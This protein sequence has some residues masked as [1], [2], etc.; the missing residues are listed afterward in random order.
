MQEA[1]NQKAIQQRMGAEPYMRPTTNTQKYVGAGIEF[2][3]DPLNLVGLP[4]RVGTGALSV[5]RQVAPTAVGGFTAGIASEA[6]GEVGKELGGTT[7]QVIGGVTGALA[8]GFGAVKLVE[9]VLGAGKTAAV[10]LKDLDLN[11]LASIEGTSRAQDLVK[12]AFEADPRFKERLNG[13][14]ERLAIVDPKFNTVAAAGVDN[15]AFRTALENEA[16]TNIQFAGELN[17]FYEDLRKAVKDKAAVLYPQATGNLPVQ[18]QKSAIAERNYA[19][20]ISAIDKRLGDISYN[21]SL[22]TDVA[23]LVR[24][25]EAQK[26]TIAKEKAVSAIISPQYE[27]VLS[28]ASKQGAMLPANETQVVL[29][30]A[31]N[32][33]RDDPWAK[34]APLLKL[35]RAQ[36]NK[37]KA[38]R[39]PSEAPNTIGGMLPA[40]RQ[41]DRS[42]G[43]DITS[44][45]SLKRRVAEDIRNVSSN[46]TRDKLKLFQQTVDEALNRV[47][48][49]AG[50]TSVKF[51][52]EDVPFGEAMKRLD[53]DY[54]EQVGIP[55]RNSDAIQK[56]SS[57]EYAEKIGT[58]LATSPT[59]ITSFLKV[60]GEEGVSIAE[61]AV[62]SKIYQKA[63][64]PKTGLLN[65]NKLELMLTKDSQN[66]G[67]RD[68]LAEVPALKGR[69]DESA[70]KMDTLIGEKQALDAAAEA[71]R[72][73]LG[74]GFL[75]DYE[76]GG[77]DSVV[78][79]MIGSSSKGYINK[80]KMDINNFPVDERISVTTALRNGLVNKMIDSSDPLSFVTN[81]KQALT[82]VFGPAHVKNLEALA[83]V[84]R[85]ATAI[86][87]N[88]LP[89]SSTALREMSALERVAQGVPL[90]KITGILVNQIASTFN[91]GFRL[92]SLIGQANLDNA[93]REAHRKLFM[94]PNGL[95]ATIKASSKIMTKN[96]KEMTIKDIIKP[97]DVADLAT[98]MMMNLGRTG[99]V[100]SQVG[101]SESTVMPQEEGD[102]YEYVP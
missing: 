55:F 1:S 42:A 82:T 75:K 32:L 44:L 73:E 41:S 62:M 68:I 30:A 63:I 91:K 3:A 57:Q 8:S 72:I 7:G 33:F 96:G 93:T 84:Q 37:F 99:V 39:G 89:I 98:S 15:I 47:E 19:Q 2:G 101:A 81:N 5:A 27:D 40:V 80:L 45:D 9:K 38:L 52:G 74:S 17:M 60:A 24:G 20:Q 61:N 100:G 56:I 66:G 13:L 85:M 94:D 12:Q 49:A 43:L 48:T 50:Q 58:Q 54:Y 4:A 28:Q 59:S 88:K 31:N 22:G 51:R 65:R 90:K 67:F 16:K 78:N 23:P 36:E 14:K 71:K 77:I 102:V 97:S 87:V 10:S 34:E 95:D 18:S 92:L 76:A 6:G 79:K 11:E 86:D 29:D 70:F 21:L 25:Q 53:T 35:V 69:L 83:D 46:T 26:L 64:D